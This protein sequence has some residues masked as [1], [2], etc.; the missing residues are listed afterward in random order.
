MCFVRW[1]TTPADGRNLVRIHDAHT[2]FVVGC[3]WSLYDEG[4][5]ATASWDC[6]VNVIRV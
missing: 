5:L 6:K 2:E 3:A 4:I 1:T